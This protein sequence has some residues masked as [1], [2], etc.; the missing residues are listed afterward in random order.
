MRILGLVFAPAMA[1]IAL[2]PALGKTVR[3][4]ALDL[5]TLTDG[6][7]APQAKGG[8]GIPEWGGQMVGGG[9]APLL[10]LVPL[11]P[12]KQGKLRHGI[13]FADATAEGEA[14]KI[15]GDL[16]RGGA[17]HRKALWPDVDF[18]GHGHHQRKPGRSGGAGG[19]YEG[20]KGPA[21]PPIVPG[22]INP[23]GQSSGPIDSGNP[24]MPE[25]DSDG[26]GDAG[27]ISPVPLPAAGW[28]MVAA[29]GAM[30]LAGR[31]RKQA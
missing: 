9:V 4:D 16:A 26:G 21:I 3:P 11:L 23:G 18:G 28:L 2:D 14:G 5:T 8:K 13:V 30:T 12:G 25:G 24:N 7:S 27:A 6:G 17:Q 19:W 31:R 15:V 20:P 29:L 10:P 22:G 1:L